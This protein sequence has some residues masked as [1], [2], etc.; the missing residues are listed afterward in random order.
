MEIKRKIIVILGPTSSGKSE[1]AIKLA[2]K[3]KG[4]VISADSRQVYKGLNIGTGKITK[5]EMGDI[6]HY[7]L[8]VISP[9]KTFTIVE[10]KEQTEKIIKDLL[11]RG[12]LPIICGG[13][14][15]YIQS[16]VEGVVLPEVPPN[17]LLRKNLEKNSLEDLQKILAKLDLRRFSNIDIKNRVRLIRAIEIA[18]HLGSVPKTKKQKNKYKSLQIGVTLP[19]HK[20]KTKIHDRLL[21][22]IKKG[23]VKETENLHKNGLSWKRMIELGLEYRFMANYLEKKITKSEFIKKL[24]TEIWHYAK[25]QMTWF[26][27]DK[28]IKW[29]SPR[30]EN[31]IQ[32]EI[33]LFLD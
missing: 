1:L 9:K 25:R 8:D 32:K 17:K 27:R 3:I 18:T 26:K 11:S 14:G 16:I 7:M 21:S 2:K 19:N 12:K 15:F 33:K 22:R 5:K 6:P 28:R 31:K 30:K 4:E 10:W 13:T 20:L 23:M 24:E 29:F